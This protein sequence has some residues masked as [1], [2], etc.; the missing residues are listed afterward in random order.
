ML[1][2]NPASAK[3]AASQPPISAPIPQAPAPPPQP[4][5]AA[6]LPSVQQLTQGL[7]KLT[8]VIQSEVAGVVN[9]FK[10]LNNQ[11]GYNQCKLVG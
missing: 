8:S 2:I 4:G 10:A 1:K 5:S 3:A 9:N 6:Q 11:Q 7:Q